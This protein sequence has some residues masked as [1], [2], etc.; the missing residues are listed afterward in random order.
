MFFSAI[1]PVPYSSRTSCVETGSSGEAPLRLL[2]ARR[3]SRP[4]HRLLSA[5]VGFVFVALFAAAFGVATTLGAPRPT[6][7][8]AARD[9]HAADD[10]ARRRAPS[11]RAR[12]RCRRRTRSGHRASRRRSPCRRHGR[13]RRRR[14]LFAGANVVDLSSNCTSAANC[15]DAWNDDGSSSCAPDRLQHQLLWHDSTA[16]STSTTTAT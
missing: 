16:A 8:V 5:G 1:V 9:G 7:P 13:A 6:A 14:G 10:D 2:M 3:G 12:S 15:R 4:R 11:R